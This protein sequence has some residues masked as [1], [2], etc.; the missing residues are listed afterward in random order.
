MNAV[1]RIFLVGVSAV[2]LTACGGSGAGGGSQGALNAFAAEYAS[3]SS[4]ATLSS[5]SANTTVNARNS[6]ATYDGVVNIGTDA[7]ANPAGAASYYGDLSVTVNFTNASTT[8]ALSGTAGN[9]VQYDSANASPKTGFGVS[10]SMTLTGA[11]TGTNESLGNGLAG[12]ASGSID[13]ISVSYTFDGNINGG[14]GQGVS[15]FF[16]PAN[17]DSG[18]GTGLALD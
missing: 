16:D 11:L 5:L 3:L 1:S 13:G 12:T 8:D 18:S 14:A 10:G 15:L 4:N 2:S 6:A 7:A 17:A 9:F